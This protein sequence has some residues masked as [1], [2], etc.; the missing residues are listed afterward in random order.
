MVLDSFSLA[1]SQKVLQETVKGTNIRFTKDASRA[2][3]EDC[4]GIPYYLQF[5]GDRLFNLKGKG[6]ITKSFYVRK[7]AKVIEALGKT[8]F[9]PRLQELKK[10]GYYHPILI[11]IAKLDEGK[12]VSFKFVGKGIPSYI[13]PYI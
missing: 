6:T 9:D 10:R 4:E 11:N 5:F 13:G 8:V 3:A 7:K 1:E 2:I 12:G